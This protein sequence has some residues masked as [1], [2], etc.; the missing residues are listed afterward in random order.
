[1]LD[2]VDAN[3][4]M[5]FHYSGAHEC[6]GFHSEMTGATV[7]CSSAFYLV[8]LLE[9]IIKPGYLQITLVQLVTVNF[10]YIEFPLLLGRKKN[11]NQGT[12]FSF[13]DRFS[14]V[15]IAEL[16]RVSLTYGLALNITLSVMVFL[17]CQVETLMISAE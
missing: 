8:V 4:C 16:V 13:A 10:L 3:A 12:S 7:L 14:V 6:L 2:H 5:G 15:F 17:A 1:M 11:S 9:N